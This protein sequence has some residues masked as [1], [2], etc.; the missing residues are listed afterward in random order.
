MDKKQKNFI[1]YNLR[2]EI[3]ILSFHWFSTYLCSCIDHSRNVTFT[4]NL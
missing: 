4:Y 2:I 1:A 3:N